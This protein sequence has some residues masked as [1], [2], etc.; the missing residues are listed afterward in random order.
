MRGKIPRL[1]IKMIIETI[2]PSESPTADYRFGIAIKTKVRSYPND[3]RIT[4]S[5]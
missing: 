3:Y 5:E 2:G 1:I 4:F